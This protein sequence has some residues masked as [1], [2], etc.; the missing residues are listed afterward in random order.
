MSNSVNGFGFPKGFH[1]VNSFELVEGHLL[2]EFIPRSGE[3]P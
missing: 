3:T 1:T 2:D